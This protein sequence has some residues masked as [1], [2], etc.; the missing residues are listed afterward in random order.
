MT[1]T[2]MRKLGEVPGPAGWPVVGNALDIRPETFHHQLEAWARQYGAA[3]RFRIASREYLAVSDPQVIAS[4]LRRR[5]DAFHRTNRLEQIAADLGFVG[6]FTANG[7][8]WRRQ[9]PMVL[10]GL[11]PGHIRA[12]LPAMADVTE[13]LRRRWEAAARAGRELDLLAELMRYTVDITTSLAF[14]KNLNTLEDEGVDTIQ[15]HLNV[16]FP[17]LLRRLLAPVDVRHWI[18]DRALE[19]HLRA[20]KAAVRDFIAAARAELADQPQ[21]RERPR[22]LIQALLAARDRPGSGVNDEDVSGN[23]FTMLLAGE[24]TTASTLAWMIWLLFRHPREAAVVR[25]EVDAV[26]AGDNQVR[27]F[28]QLGRLDAIQACAYET[29]RLKPVAPLIINEAMEEALV[30][31]VLVPRG[32]Y[33]MCVMRPAAI[34]AAVLE[35][36]ASFQPSR[37]T[38]PVGTTGLRQ[39]SMPF[40]AGPR[41]CPG[42][43][44]ALAEIRMAAAMLLS[45]FELE[46]VGVPGGGEPHEKFTFVMAPENLRM[47]LRERAGGAA[48]AASQSA[49]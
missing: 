19:G 37:W 1:A 21:L 24:D 38:A 36:A 45:C 15:Q 23:V 17:V 4:V 10:A 47:R 30:G 31:D 14:G 41:M 25:A 27:A 9:R 6:V 28:E 8:T 46:D 39:A 48:G 3:F 29:M 35:Q 7:D 33:V 11:D 32:A 20:L 18:P 40:G 43:Y 26:L 12:F 22:N 5:P 34:D 42:R 2:T 49:G 16:I 13:R 44:L